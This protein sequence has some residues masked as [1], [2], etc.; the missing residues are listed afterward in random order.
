MNVDETQGWFSFAAQFAHEHIEKFIDR[1]PHW[2]FFATA[3]GAVS[4]LLSIVNVL[5]VILGVGAATFGFIAGFYTMRSA[6][7]N[8]LR[9][10]AEDSKNW[11]ASDSNKS[12]KKEWRKE[13]K[14]KDDET[15]T[16]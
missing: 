16:I 13:Q 2:G 14:A 8:W 11:A 12:A 7:R 1:H 4:S 15:T 9:Q 10:K 3:T 6:R 5:S